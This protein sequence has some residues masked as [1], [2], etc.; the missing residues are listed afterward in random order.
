M[1]H[2]IREGRLG[3]LLAALPGIAR[4]EMVSLGVLDAKRYAADNARLQLE[5]THGDAVMVKLALFDAQ[6]MEDLVKDVRKNFATDE[7][8]C[9]V[10]LPSS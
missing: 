10:F 2:I 3:E 7:A 5:L 8:R 4:L 6:K 9:A 1:P